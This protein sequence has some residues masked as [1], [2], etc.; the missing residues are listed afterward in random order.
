MNYIKILSIIA[1]C[2]LVHS[3]SFAQEKP[4]D[5]LN[6]F[7]K[8]QIELGDNWVKK[9]KM[10]DAIKS[11]NI[12]RILADV[13]ETKQKQL[14]FKLDSTFT[15]IQ[16]LTFEAK[17][18]YLS[19]EASRLSPIQ[20]IQLLKVAADI[21]ANDPTIQHNIKEQ[22]RFVFNTSAKHAFR[23]K[24]RFEDCSDISFS[25]KAKW[26]VVTKNN[27]QKYIWNA[28]QTPMNLY[29]ADTNIVKVL[30]AENDSHVVTINAVKQ[31]KLYHLDTLQYAVEIPIKLNGNIEKV[32]F[33]A[34]N[35]FLAVAETDKATLFH[36]GDTQLSM[37]FSI[38]THGVQKI[39]FSK[40]S[41][42][43][44]TIP[45]SAQ[46][47]AHLWNP[48]TQQ[49]Y[50]WLSN[51]K[52]IR[53]A[54][55]SSDSRWLVTMNEKG[56]HKLWNLQ[57]QKQVQPNP[58]IQRYK[59]IILSG[60]DKKVVFIDYQ[61][62][63]KLYQ[64]PLLKEIPCEP[65]N[66]SVEFVKFFPIQ[67]DTIF[68]K[69]ADGSR[70]VMSIKNDTIF[71]KHT[72]GRRK[73]MSIK[74]A[75]PVEYLKDANLLEDVFVSNDA[76]WVLTFNNNLYAYKLWN[77]KY[78]N[79]E[80]FNF[81][82]NIQ[83]IQFSP[84]AKWIFTKHSNNQGK[85][86]QIDSK[87]AETLNDVKEFSY[88]AD[89]KWLMVN[90]FRGDL[91][92]SKMDESLFKYEKIEKN[93]KSASFSANGKWGLITYTSGDVKLIRLSDSLH[94]I[95]I[96][97][98]LKKIQDIRL[99]D[100]KQGF[101]LTHRNG[102]NVNVKLQK[103]SFIYTN[104]ETKQPT[105][106]ALIKKFKPIEMLLKAYYR[107]DSS[108]IAKVRL[109][110]KEELQEQHIVTIN[111]HQLWLSK[112]VEGTDFNNTKVINEHYLLVKVGRA[113]IKTDV[114]KPGDW[115]SYGD[116]E[117]MDYDD[118][119]IENWKKTFAQQF[120]LPLEQEIVEKYKLKEIEKSIQAK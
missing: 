54:Q 103:G 9:G 65:F 16:N 98:L 116:G 90:D 106:T 35:Q 71:V 73:V 87:L 102:D 17:A 7:Y 95:S 13:D 31:A 109:L 61:Y 48:T 84:D 111:N 70:K 36:I 3:F 79:L 112:E 51:E 104:S 78:G 117:E 113:L 107:I 20:N 56:E 2:L 93:V 86:W 4:V 33:S 30:F 99:S 44:L 62:Q 114:T 6:K 46:D 12:A 15:A 119:A 94:I 39:V 80:H 66:K 50:F 5:K 22:E 32:Y 49:E 60:D 23:E 34:D 88:S 67:S 14:D 82:K 110:N 27:N 47:T 120:L 74:K 58:K 72:D 81:E 29:I 40:D 118:K 55:F 76:A 24:K 97:N 91:R 89:G 45:V 108:E 37:P 10:A 101:S 25:P 75:R 52:E 64:L 41:Q 105:K 21:T 26:L 1:T 57:T 11:Y 53:S 77:N 43:M 69:Y 59:E 28:T 38:A 19:S 115:F 63:A 68:V 96:K 100:D 18:L 8:Q 92:I 42:W 83:K 85:I